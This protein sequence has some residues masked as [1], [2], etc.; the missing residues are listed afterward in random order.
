MPPFPRAVTSLQNN[1]LIPYYLSEVTDSFSVSL[2]TLGFKSVWWVSICCNHYYDQN[3]HDLVVSGQWEPL[4]WL[5][6][7]LLSLCI[8]R[9]SVELPFMSRCSKLFCIFSPDPRQ[10]C[11]HVALTFSGEVAFL[12]YRAAFK[13]A[14]YS[15]VVTV[16]RPFQ[17]TQ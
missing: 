16:S 17:G 14:H 15:C 7:R 5:F 12:G 3:S 8:A 2:W 10:S 13:G 4:G 6:W 9:G 11:L 1:K